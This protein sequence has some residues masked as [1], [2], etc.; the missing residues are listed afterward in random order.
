MQPSTMA[1]QS[2]ANPKTLFKNMTVSSKGPI[3]GAPS[4]STYWF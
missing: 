4:P 1:K 3:V 2:L